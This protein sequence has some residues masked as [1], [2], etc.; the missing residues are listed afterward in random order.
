MPSDMLRG[1]SWCLSAHGRWTRVEEIPVIECRAVV[2][3]ATR[4]GRTNSERNTCIL[5]LREHVGSLFFYVTEFANTE[6]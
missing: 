5:F 1:E 4:I 2:I 6:S 3:G